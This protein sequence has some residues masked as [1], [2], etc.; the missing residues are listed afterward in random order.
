MRYF[1]SILVLACIWATLLSHAFAAAPSPL[2][3]TPCATGAP[4]SGSIGETKLDT[5][6]IDI[7]A[8]VYIDAAH[9]AP[10]NPG[11]WKSM[12]LGNLGTSS[13]NTAPSVVN[14]P[15]TGLF[16]PG[17][18]Q[19]AV[20]TGG[21]QRLVVDQNGYVGIGTPA[22]S[23]SG[24]TLDINDPTG[25]GIRL[26]S[27]STNQNDTLQFY[28]KDTYG[29]AMGMDGLAGTGNFFLNWDATP[30]T[31]NTRLLTV[32]PNA[33]VGINTETPQATL[34]VNGYAR[35]RLNS[36]APATC[37][38]NNSGAIALN[39]AAQICTCDG[40]HWINVTGAACAW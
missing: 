37:G 2:R 8:C 32:T 19:V 24:Q 13:T 3:G 4:T 12:V 14:D 15:G 35:L 7:V 11:V 27:F 29:Y 10:P 39:H 22:P 33:Q 34:D 28:Y 40:A 1:P 17:L 38:A 31:E 36:A 25:A 9:N 21:V 26:N 20:A 18:S 6:N 16:T 30:N 5:D 23:Q